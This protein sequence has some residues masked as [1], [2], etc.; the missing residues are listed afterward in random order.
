ME[1]FFVIITLRKIYEG[2]EKGRGF[3]QD[4]YTKTV[5]EVV[6]QFN[7]SSKQGLTEAEAKQRLQRYGKNLLVENKGRTIGQMILEQFT[8]FLVLILFVAS[9]VS[10]ALGEYVDGIVIVLIIVLNAT[11]G[12]VQEYKA[13]NALQALKEMAAPQAKVI[14]GGELHKIAADQLV[15]GDVIVLEAGD[16]VPADLRLVE[17]MNLKIEEAALTGESVPVEKFAEE[18]I[19]E[20][21]GIGD[22]VNSAFMGTIVTYGRGRGIVTDTGMKTEMGSIARMLEKV[23]E[24][25]TILQKK[26]ASFG[27]KLGIACLGICILVFILGMIR[28]EPFMQIFMISVSLA[29]AAI[30]EGLP[31]VVTVVLALGMQRMV[32]RNA[33]I[34]RLSAV[35]T[36][37]STTI[38]C[39]DKTGTL[40]QNKMTVVEIFDGID[41]WEVTGRG[42]VAEGDI[43][44]TNDTSTKKEPIS[45]EF[46]LQAGVLCNDAE[47][48]KAEEDIIGDPTE[49]A[50]LVAG[51]KRGYI[52]EKLEQQYPRIEE[53]PFDSKRKLMSTFHQQEKDIRM[54]TKGAPD[55]ILNRCEFILQK[56]E[57]IPL[58]E[59]MKEKIQK[60]N[61]YFANKALR[62]LG[63]AYKNID[64][65]ER[66]E[67]QENELIFLGLV[68]M[69]DPPREEAKKAV[70]LCKQAGIQP[71][72]ITGDHKITATAIGKAIGIIEKEEETMDGS[73]I[74]QYNDKTFREK[75][76]KVR[77]FA[78]VSPQH[79]VRIV[80]A[81]QSNDEI[82]AMTGDG[83][84][85]A[86][87]LKQADIGI[88]MG[89]TGTDVSKEAADM[90]LTDD[91][92]SSI[93]DAVEE[94]RI[95]YS[96]IRK[97]V[98]FLLSCN[99]GELLLIFIAM[100][101]GW[102]VPLLPIQ[103]LWLNLITDS[104]PA[105]ALGLEQKEEGIMSKPPR[106]PQE[107]IVD[108]SMTITIIAQSIALSVVALVAFQYGL[109][110]L[111]SLEAGRTSCFIALILGELL[112]AYS[113]RSEH[114]SL[115]KMKIFSNQFLNIAILSALFLLLFVV[116]VPF[117]QSIFRTVSLSF[118]DLGILIVLSFIPL[119]GGE[120][121][122]RFK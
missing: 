45:L 22:R 103:L 58:T 48:K 25:G 8:D 5:E 92:F 117:L 69:I 39:T 30:P 65:L 76:K 70:A 85:D 26:L 46:L 115:F 66:V 78:R 35:E 56:E 110:I 10:I 42:Y 81:I 93:V 50:L 49:G 18:W 80:K 104:F 64:T 62:V 71:V 120:I 72:M 79:K 107:S 2:E 16:Y 51:E 34:K 94:G 89:I 12:V 19:Q 38:I 102:P 100:L 4:F 112:R 11:L 24:D 73:E 98:G 86:P 47:F 111:G 15:P 121:A 101:L 99:I 118:S 57:V 77:V 36:L 33:I 67:E 119:I 106:D 59:R 55:I 52:K 74:D 29:V 113:A 43:L 75:V 41:F 21:V 31:A 116:Y 122:K 28:Q 14:R 53:L 61:D 82:V 68:G 44:P 23:E 90:I 17:S 20:K 95:I 9:I 96:N 97:F 7:T 60:A 37:G 63:L 13:S 83:V 84:N 32:K 27:K 87:S 1:L 54:Y 88:A 105:F 3:M 114:Q 6:N 91:N 40:T 109:Q 108:R